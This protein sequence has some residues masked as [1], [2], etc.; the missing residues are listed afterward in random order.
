M[1]NSCTTEAVATKLDIA[2]HLLI[3]G[4]EEAFRHVIRLA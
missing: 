4:L 1:G 2:D 3:H